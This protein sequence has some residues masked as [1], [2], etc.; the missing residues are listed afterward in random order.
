M[1]KRKQPAW[2]QVESSAAKVSFYLTGES[3]VR[4][5]TIPDPPSSKTPTVVRITHS[6]VYGRVDSEVFVRLGDPSRP[7][8]VQDFDTVADWRKAKL[9]EDLLW[10]DERE[11]WISRSKAK[12]DTSVWSGTYEAELQ[13]SGGHQQIELKLISRVPQVCS[14]V[15][16]N[17]KVYVRGAAPKRAVPPGGRGAGAGPAPRPASANLHQAIA[18]GNLQ[19]VVSLSRERVPDPDACI[20]AIQGR[21]RDMLEAL[22]QAG[23]DLNTRESCR[24]YTPLM[25]ALRMRDFESVKLLLESGASPDAMGTFG[26]P[27]TYAAAEGFAEIAGWFIRSGANLEQRDSA[28]ATPLIRASRNG[29]DEVVRLLLESG[30]D[31]DSV[32]CVKRTALDNA[33]EYGQK[34]IAALLG[35]YQGRPTR[36]RRTPGKSKLKTS[37]TGKRADRRR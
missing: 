16:S 20:R 29:H 36:T 33:V 8:G 9:V 2:K 26:P 23:A 27:L 21:R 24:G 1:A 19:Q 4:A 30:A 37:A 3:V 17:W 25:V 10:S 6:N 11:D 31:P 28:Q 32:D 7:L 5:V 34:K 15:L 14:I 13:F 18:Q 12:G 22:I 35:T